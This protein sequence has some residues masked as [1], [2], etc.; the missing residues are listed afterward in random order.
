[1]L[2]VASAFHF[3][4]LFLLQILPVILNVHR[5]EPSSSSEELDN[6]G[7]LVGKLFVTCVIIL[8][9]IA[10]LQFVCACADL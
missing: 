5:W 9:N 10:Y 1:M 7:D 4:C 8:Y 3:N 2:Y 6:V